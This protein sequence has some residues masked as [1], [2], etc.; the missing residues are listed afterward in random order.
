MP[1]ENHIGN[2]VKDL[3]LLNGLNFNSFGKLIDTSDVVIRNVITGRN[4]PSFDIIEKILLAFESI[5]AEW[6]ITGGGEMLKK[7]EGF[8]IANESVNEYSSNKNNAMDFKIY[9]LLDTVTYLRKE[10][11]K[12]KQELDHYR[13][14]IPGKHPQEKKAL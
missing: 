10:N 4:K 8:L 14:V 12:L 7:E 11:E 1:K 5:N 6:L 13:N 2:R 3:M 9:D